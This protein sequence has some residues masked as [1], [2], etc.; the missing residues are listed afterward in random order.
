M[1]RVLLIAAVTLGVLLLIAAALITY[2]AL[3]LNS[4]VRNNRQYVL[5]RV[6]D[7]LGRNVA[8]QDVQVALGWGVSLEV[9]GLQIADDP[10]FS[11]RPF[12]E[13]KQMSGQIE[14]LP[15]LSGQILVT[16]LDLID[17]RVRIV[18]DRAGRLNVA[19]LGAKNAAGAGPARASRVHAPNAIPIH[20]LVQTL[21]IHEGTVSY[22]DAAAARPIEA[23]HLSLNVSDVNPTR[24]FL[25]KLQLAALGGSRNFSLSGKVGPLMQQ[26]MLQPL[27][28]PFSFDL[29]AGPILLDRL[30]GIPELRS[31]IPGKLSMP[32]PITLKMKIKGTLDAATFDLESD[33]SAARLLYLGLFNKPAG[34]PFQISAVGFRRGAGV[35][36]SNA[37]VKLAGLQAKISEVKFARG[38]WSAKIDTNRF[39]LAPIAKM[40][41]G[42]ARY[43]LSGSSEA[44][45]TLASAAPMPRAYGIIAMTGVGLKVEGGKLP[46]IS[47][48]T[49]TVR[50]DGNSAVLEPATFNLGSARAGLQG[51]AS[52]LQPLRA[53]YSFNADRFKLAELMPE[54]P[55]DE[56]VLQMRAN[57]T[58]AA[59]ND[60]LTATTVLTSTQG[61]V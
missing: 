22:N 51:Q 27:E 13:A 5:D 20:F 4:L 14:L 37:A 31:R 1:R 49:G 29:I 55:P 58:V 61:M 41:A 34:T 50:V 36:V 47:A 26:G 54:R 18:R 16:R 28:A 43:E 32:D 17:P 60:S 19:T 56:E 33:L 52:S 15:L 10:A 57:G 59:A 7:S 11:Q 53:S 35:G 38:S 8:A 25:V 2:G 48:L 40:A 42:L 39:E 24:P 21:T 9:S 46:G 44:H 12:I 23:D 6:G 30:R 45:L 3:N